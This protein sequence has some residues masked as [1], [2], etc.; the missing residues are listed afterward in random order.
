MLFELKPQPQW[1]ESR[2]FHLVQQVPLHPA[3]KTK[4]FS[5]AWRH[6]SSSPDQSDNIYKY[7]TKYITHI[8]FI[9]KFYQ[10]KEQYVKKVYMNLTVH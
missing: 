9:T 3:Q 7:K 6:T 1:S 4:D 8:D 5:S 2:S 10:K